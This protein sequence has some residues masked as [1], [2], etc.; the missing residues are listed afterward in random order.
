ME[1]PA[2]AKKRAGR[3]KLQLGRA[4]KDP[5][6]EAGG[7]GDGS[8]DLGDH[9]DW[10]S[11]TSSP[12]RKS[13]SRKSSGG[14]GWGADEPWGDI[15]EPV[16]KT[17][18]LAPVTAPQDTSGDGWG[19]GGDGDGWGDGG[20]DGWGGSPATSP[21]PRTREIPAAQNDG[22]GQDAD[23][24]ASE[25]K[26][27]PVEDGQ[28]SR[29]NPAPHVKAPWLSVPKSPPHTHTHTASRHVAAKAAREAARLQRKK[30][31]EARLEAKRSASGSGSSIGARKPMKLGLGKPKKAD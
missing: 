12:S 3:G 31:R 30:E 10:G 11:S 16:S 17:G 22:W 28:W 24:W 20:G 9:G 26:A 13:P 2:P 15:E 14:D 29:S 19:D 21:A 5:S 7:W 27:E 1:E 23:G 18:R 25:E 8:F 4:A 6:D